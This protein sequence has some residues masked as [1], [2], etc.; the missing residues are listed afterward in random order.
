MNDDPLLLLI[1]RLAAVS[2][3]GLTFASSPFDLQRYREV[4][5]IAAELASFGEAD[6]RRV[7][8]IF[9]TEDGY[10]TP[11]L[12]VR[13]AVFRH[14]TD[15]D[16]QI[17][18]VREIADD[19]WTLPGGWIDIG[20]SPAAAAERE[21]REETGLVVRAEKLAALFDKRRHDH[22]L[23]PHHAYLLFFLCRF[24]SGELTP[25]IETSEAA[26]FGETS[27]PELSTGRA[28]RKQILR[29]FEHFRDPSLPTDFD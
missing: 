23:A 7:A 5:E 26:W 1:Q 24:E 21:V 15:Q 6:A 13:S 28:N 29:M 22:P 4:A 3:T 10:A 8:A 20:E 25:S 19:L 12:I 9:G 18:M 16:P 14:G 11:K 17:L 2:Q 27:L